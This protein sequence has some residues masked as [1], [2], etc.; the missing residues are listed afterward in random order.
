[1]P[2][3]EALLLAYMRFVKEEK[4]S[5]ELLFAKCLETD[6]KDEAIFNELKRFFDVKAIS[7]SNILSIATDSAPAMVGQHRGFLA[8]LKQTI[9]NVL[10]VH[11]VIHRQHLIDKNLSKRLHGSLDYI[12]RAVNKIKRNEL[13]ER[14][15]AQH[16]LK[17]DDD[18]NSLLLNTEVRWLY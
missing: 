12:I 10:S 11:C 14:L 8:Y 9:P 3:N 18:Y 2:G 4:I 16:C 5:Q 15:F 7:L 6:T 13:N 17:N 1:M